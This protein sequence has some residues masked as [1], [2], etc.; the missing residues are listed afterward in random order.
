VFIDT[1]YLENPFAAG[2]G[3][4]VLH[5]KVRNDGDKNA[6]RLNLKLSINDI[7]T[8][9]TTVSIPAKGTGETS[10]D[11]SANLKGLNEGKISFNDFPVTFDN[12]FYLALNFTDKINVLE[13]RGSDTKTAIEK[14]FGNDQVFNVT[15]YAVSNFTYSLLAQADLVVV[16]G[17]NTVNSPLATALRGYI[18]N[19]GTVLFA[20]GSQPDVSNL[21]NFL[22]LPML[23]RLEQ[24][25][26]QEMDRPDFSNPFFENVFEEKSVSIHMPR[27]KKMLD[28]GNDRSAI[29]RF[30][31][32][33][34][35]LSR[36]DQGGTLYVLASALQQ[37]QTDFFN[38]ALFVPV[39]Y[40]IASRAKKNESKLY[41]TLHESFLNLRFDSL[42]DDQ[43]LRWIGEDE[44]VPSQRKVNDQVIFDLPKFS[45]T[46]GFYKVVA[47][48]DTLSLLA[49]D[50]DKSESLLDQYPGEEMKN[51]MGSGDNITIFQVGSSEAF[52]NEIKE[53]YLGTP[54]WKYALALSIFFLLMEI[55]LIRFLK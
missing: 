26:Q 39:M 27:A 35:F 53:R 15:S 34:P 50:L 43:P 14:V 22:Q 29:L 41:Y 8:A 55:L 6:E 4:N 36:F 37:D 21:K 45:I 40:R 24:T 19:S 13:I 44:V 31:N 9:T 28:W 11:L 32:D 23:Q 52:S 51:L 1:C 5:V 25:D 38:H 10:F 42:R 2:G 33:Q 12:E 7:Q 20:P 49:F 17:L 46:K 47:A 30:K 54:L 3:K 48:Q 18:S 16:N